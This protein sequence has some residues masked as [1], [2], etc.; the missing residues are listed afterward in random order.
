MN[1]SKGSIYYLIWIIGALILVYYG[2]Q[3][4]IMMERKG[5]HLFEISYSL[6]GNILYGFVLGMYLSLL[7]GLPSKRKFQRPLF[8]FV[9][10]PSL[11]LT[12]YVV[13]SFYL[14]LPYYTLY[15]ELTSQHGFFYFTMLSGLTFMKSLFGSK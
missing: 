12:L 13:A 2:N 8:I 10:L 7:N 1:K 9:F 6:I 4:L 11:V 5:S 15:L 3:F 14:K